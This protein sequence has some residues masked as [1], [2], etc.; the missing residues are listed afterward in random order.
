MACH[1]GYVAKGRLGSLVSGLG[2]ILPGFVLVLLASWLFF[3]YGDQNQYIYEYFL[4]FL[5]KKYIKYND[6]EF[7]KKKK[8]KK[9]RKQKKITQLMN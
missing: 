6:K 9:K 3:T 2:F 5:F 4:F 8:K 7:K 1:F